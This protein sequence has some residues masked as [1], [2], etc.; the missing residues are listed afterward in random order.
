VSRR[1]GA[2]RKTKE[3]RS[4]NSDTEVLPGFYLETYATVQLS[5]RWS[6]FAAG[7]YDWAGSLDGSVGPSEFNVDLGG[8]TAKAG[9][10]ISF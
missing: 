3:W 1:G 9:I 7:R 6:L 2:Y 8:W 4:S 10:T 5:S